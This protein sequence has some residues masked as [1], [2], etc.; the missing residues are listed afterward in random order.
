MTRAGAGVQFAD[1]GGDDL[2][3]GGNIVKAS[4]SRVTSL[5][6]TYWPVT[7]SAWMALSELYFHTDRIHT[8]A[9][10]CFP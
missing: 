3:A 7:T 8:M 5:I 4:L 10:M 9:V 1:F 6:H 2:R